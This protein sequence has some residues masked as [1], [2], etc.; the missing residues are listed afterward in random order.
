MMLF[1]DGRPEHTRCTAEFQRILDHRGIVWN[2]PI[3]VLSHL[4]LGRAYA[5]AG[6]TTKAR[7]AFHVAATSSVFVC[8]AYSFS[9][10]PDRWIIWPGR[11][12][13]KALPRE[14]SERSGE[15]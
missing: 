15:P 2:S 6:D 3:G 4:Q 10:C 9:L 13:V 12:A 14:R 7:A 1:L 8:K 11:T 5:M